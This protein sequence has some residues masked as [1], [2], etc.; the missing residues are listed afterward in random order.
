MLFRNKKV[1][2]LVVSLLVGITTNCFAYTWV[3]TERPVSGL[4]KIAI[5]ALEGDTEGI[6]YP[7][8]VLASKSSRYILGNAKAS[9][10]DGYIVWKVISK[11][12]QEQYFPERFETLTFSESVE[13]THDYRTELLS[14]SSYTQTLP[15]PE[16]WFSRGYVELRADIYD[17]TD[18]LLAQFRETCDGKDLSEAFGRVVDRLLSDPNSKLAAVNGS[19]KYAGKKPKPP[20]PFIEIDDVTYEGAGNDDDQIIRYGI[21]QIFDKNV[22]IFQ[23][24]CDISFERP[25]KGENF[26][27]KTKISPSKGSGIYF[28]GPSVT[29]VDKK[30]T[31]EYQ[32]YKDNDGKTT[33]TIEVVRKYQEPEYSDGF[34]GYLGNRYYVYCTIVDGKTNQEVYASKTLSVYDDS[35]GNDFDKFYKKSVDKLRKYIKKQSKLRQKG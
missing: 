22:Q 2:G 23:E 33:H 20:V 11:D 28:R 13:R 29:C 12:Y 15:V 1:V 31:L 19:V 21:Q 24:T 16:A 30:E 34:A 17:N 7:E 18:C 26:I 5:T 27:L 32:S 3:N 25:L 14:S 35:M 4:N 8:G 6:D 9:G 10:T